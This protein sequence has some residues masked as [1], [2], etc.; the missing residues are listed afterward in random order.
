MTVNPAKRKIFEGEPAPGSEVSLGSPM[1]AESL[2]RMTFD[3]V[4]VDT[5]RR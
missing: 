3:F 4:L 2:S 1:S 5:Q